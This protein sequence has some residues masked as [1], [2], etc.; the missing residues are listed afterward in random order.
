MA[1]PLQVEIIQDDDT[2]R[3]DPETGTIETPTGDGGVVVQLNARPPQ[4][5]DDEDKFYAN[6]AL[7]MSPEELAKIANDLFDAIEA[8]DRSRQGSLEIYKRALDL[9]GLKLAEPRAAVDSAAG[10]DGMSSVVNPLMLEH[11]LKGWANAEAELLP[12]NGP[13][14]V[15]DDG[16][17]TVDRD[18]LAEAYERGM[19]HYLTVTAPEYYPD[20]SHMLLWGTH[21]RGSGFKK[22]YRCPLRRRPVSESVGAE[23]LIVSDT[24]KDLRSCARITHQIPMRP[25]VMKRMIH[26]GAY[27]DA[28]LTQPTS[29]PNQV[30]EAVGAIQKTG[31][32]RQRPEDEPYTIWESQCE[33]DL[34]E[35]AP[36]EFKNTD[37]PMPFLVTMDKDSREILA[38]RRDWDEDDSQAQ[39]IRMYVRYPYVP[40]PGFYGTGLLNIL[41]NCSA[42]MTAAWRISL[43][44]GMFANFPGG[45]IDK[46]AT[47]QNSN[48]QRPGPG[49]FAPV[50]AG[51]KD[52]RAV[53]MAM[54]YKDVS[55]GMLA[56][57]DKIKAQADAAGAAPTIPVGEG[58]ANVPVG[59]MLAAVEQATKV[60]SAAFK[61]MHTAQSEEIQLLVDL[62]RAHPEDFWRNNKDQPDYWTKEKLYQ[63]ITDYNLVP[64]SDPNVP[65]HIHR[66]AK[67]VAL[68][69]IFAIPQFGAKMDADETLRR[70]LRAIK[71][72]PRGLIIPPE[73]QAAAAASAPPDPKMIEAQAKIT[74]AQTNQLTAT[75]KAQTAQ[76]E[77]ALKPQ[78]LQTERDIAA[79]H[80]Q[81]ES[82]IHGSDS[83]K[84]EHEQAMERAQHG[85]NVQQA[86]GEHARE[87]TRL[88]HDISQDHHERQMDV[89]QHAL[90]TFEATKPEPKPAAKPKAKT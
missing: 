21:L 27:R 71:E 24:M 4:K 12:A 35:F 23:D 29:Q 2:A 13:V 15:K 80:L 16:D 65:S 42:A 63:A 1:E 26:A 34:A 85:L 51:G 30:D 40:G 17:E 68:S 10:T 67:G 20:T 79:S 43:D 73:A 58:L 14:K 22:V 31:V 48:I 59:T 81:A 11:T 86:A 19:N 55:A 82:I 36:S 3:V 76:Q 28:T 56:L 88:A 87:S 84:I 41:G 60:M 52:I 6:L 49:E 47:R 70:I 33:L 37:I 72:D 57:M 18:E 9:T 38:I 75:T 77:A 39:R 8:D 45:L 44:C 83:A 7:K 32:I 90:D 69:Q 25:S 78:E 66:V 53:I 54:P 64:V 89:A 5:A 61:G 62:F 46:G 74:T 50:D